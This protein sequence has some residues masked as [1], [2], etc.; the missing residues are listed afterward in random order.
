VCGEI[1][2]VSTYNV[3]LMSNCRCKCGVTWFI[4]VHHIYR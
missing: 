4:V 2:A 1:L 3:E